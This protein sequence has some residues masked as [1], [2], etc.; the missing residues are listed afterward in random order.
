MK[1]RITILVENSTPVPG[2]LGEYGFSALVDVN[3]STFLF[4]TGSGEAI[5]A[6]ARTLGIDW[7]TIDGLVLSHGHF[8]HTGGVTELLPQM[9]RPRVFAHPGIFT[10]H[11]IVTG[12]DQTRYIG[13]SFQQE[14]L[15]AAGAQFIPTPGFTAIADGVYVTGSIPRR[16][17][18]EGPGGPF[19]H[20]VDGEVIPDAIED[21]MAMVIDH[22]QGLIILSGCAHA[23]MINM[24]NYARQQCN[25]RNILAFIGG[26]HLISAD[27]NRLQKTIA[28][29]RELKPQHLIVSHCTGFAAAAR[30]MREL[31]EMAKKGETGMVFEF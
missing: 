11:Q 29:L 15:T 17:D 25:H 18:Y 23:G 14:D 3:N 20:D 6:N 24:I 10:R 12:P 27:E 5:M 2:L 16:N 13:M 30:L 4:D 19:V 8:D 31:P 28:A 9:H 26:T 22:P 1:V 21:D 7:S